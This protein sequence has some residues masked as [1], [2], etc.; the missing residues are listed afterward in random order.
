[1]AA[2]QTDLPPLLDAIFCRLNAIQLFSTNVHVGIFMQNYND[3]HE[4]LKQSIP[5]LSKTLKR[6]A[7]YILDHPGD[8]A[9]LSMRK[10]AKKAGVPAPNFDRLAKLLGYG[11]YSEL[12]KIYQQEV[13]RDNISDYHLRAELL[14]ESGDL[15]GN[16]A[17][18]S[19]L[20]GSAL[21]N[22]AKLYDMIDPERVLEIVEKLQ[23]CP[24]IFVVGA[25]ASWSFATYLKYV[26][27]MTSDQFRLLGSTGGLFADDLVDI[28]SGDAIIAIAICPCAQT[29]VE[30]SKIA[31][32]RSCL[33][34]G[35]TDRPSSPLAIH[36]D[37]ILSA[38]TES[39][40]FFE[41]YLSTVA[42][43]EMLLAF[44]TINQG[45]AAV[46]RIESIESD[47]LRLG[48]YWND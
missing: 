17:I 42:I 4:K 40:L 32:E 46:Q 7:A 25:Q 14:Q 22:I 27:G 21:I 31:Q 35:I 15:D 3:I 26:G 30:V 38:P 5:D 44:Y 39:P 45:A 43:I 29:T 41:S 12:R 6:S 11:T 18:W 37:Y 20:R 16:E 24:R 23:Q 2:A 1:M 9:T 34:V 10:V 33:V 13:Q 47:R 8:V 28:K 48:E 36:C 19:D